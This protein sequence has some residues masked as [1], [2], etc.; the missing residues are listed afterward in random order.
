MKG[1]KVQKDKHVISLSHTYVQS[2]KLDLVEL[3]AEW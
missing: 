3:T 1:A 2:N